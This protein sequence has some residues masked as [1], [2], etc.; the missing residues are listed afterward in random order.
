MIREACRSVTRAASANATFSGHGKTHAA[1]NH[2]GVSEVNDADAAVAPPH[3]PEPPKLRARLAHKL[4][5]A[6][7]LL[8]IAAAAIAGV[9]A[10]A[11]TE[12]RLETASLEQWRLLHDDVARTVSSLLDMSSDSL[13]AIAAEL[14]APD[15]AEDLRVRVAQRLLE[16]SAALDH[17]AV[18]DAADTLIDVLREPGAADVV[19]PKT[20]PPMIARACAEGAQIAAEPQRHGNTVR[21]P[22]TAPIRAEVGRTGCAVSF[23][24]LDVVEERLRLLSRAHFAQPSEGVWLVGADGE[25]L[26]QPTAEDSPS[27]SAVPPWHARFDMAALSA[28][29]FSVQAANDADGV[30]LLLA[31]RLTGPLGLGVLV[32]SSPARIYAAVRATR[33]AVWTAVGAVGVVALFAAWLFARRVTRPLAALVEQAAQLAKRDFTA[34]SRVVSRDEVGV[35]ALALNRA[36]EALEASE[37]Q[38][39]RDAAVR[40]D[41]ARYLPAEWVEE[42]LARRA[43]MG[44]GGRRMDISVLFADVVAFT[45]ISERLEPDMVVRLL[46][47][48]FTILSEIVFRHGGIVDKFV[49]DCVMALFG[50]P[51]ALESHRE[52]SL[53][54]AEDMMRWME[55][56]A[57]V[58]AA[59][60]QVEVRIA[61]GMAAGT[62]VVGNVGS[63]RRMEYTAV[64]DVVNVAA[65]L[66]HMA[67][68]GQ[69]LATASLCEGIGGGL[70][71]IDLGPIMVPGREEPVR[72]HEVIW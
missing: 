48:I 69:I 72:V 6:T 51:R 57:P 60:Y 2:N 55:T 14:A 30:P 41:L 11:V 15:T 21:L 62:C 61:I 66:E 35:V 27:K 40:A 9:A 45:P 67:A 52:R 44:L 20:L 22:L 59:K 64:G 3:T 8:T 26:A 53:R 47:D 1:R 18:Y 42:V 36:S 7:A 65:R 17:V 4:F 29:A 43:D 39:K 33:A 54:A 28:H 5:A 50:P 38:V 37:A 58:L 12:E 70:R 71:T 56:G 68:A 13:T 16:G 32:V 34:R 23:V 24:P 63:E 49:G 46:N 19:A 25:V 31:G 10:S